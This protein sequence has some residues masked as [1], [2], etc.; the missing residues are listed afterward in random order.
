MSATSA[1]HDQS[2]RE[3]RRARD[4]GDQAAAAERARYAHAQRHVREEVERGPAAEGERRDRVEL[5]RDVCERR[6]HR[7]REEDDAGHHRQMQVGVDI[8][9]KGDALTPLRSVR[10]CRARIGKK[11]KYASQ[12]DV[13]TT[14]PSTAATITP[15]P[16]PAASRAEADGDQR[17]ADRDDHDQPV[18]LDEVRGLQAPAAHAT[19]QRPEEADCRAPR[20][21]ARLERAVDE[22]RG[23][24]QRRAE[25]GPTERPAGSPPAGRDHPVPRARTARGA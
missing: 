18:P 10:S 17:L 24:D 9:R 19:E 15:V 2:D 14:S 11:S 4:R 12:N 23:E 22:S 21:K 1:G 6:L 5:V 20:A 16:S 25:R 8:A 7:E 13:A 3:Q